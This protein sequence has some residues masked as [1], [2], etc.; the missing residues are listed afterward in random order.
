MRDVVVSP[1]LGVPRARRAEVKVLADEAL[2][3]RAV[4]H[5]V[6]SVARG[7]VRRAC[8]RRRGSRALELRARGQERVECAG[9]LDGEESVGKA[10]L[11]EDVRARD[12]A[13]AEVEVGAAH[14]LPARAPDTARAAVARHAW[15]LNTAPRVADGVVCAPQR[16]RRDREEAVRRVVREP[17]ALVGEAG[18]AEVV[19]EAFEAFM[20]W[21]A[22]G[23]VASI[24]GDPWMGDIFGIDAVGVICAQ[25]PGKGYR[26]ER[27]L[28]VVG[29]AHG[30]ISETWGAE[31]IVFT[32]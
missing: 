24:A 3:P 20:S 21:T 5:L 8:C 30:R 22:N 26:E 15:V 23:A 16:G 25:V 9:E 6:A 2:V 13:L 32:R 12:A 29:L 27:V 11:R 14:A 7:L 17:H 10:V 19:V 4:D 28:G 31:V 1:L 18:V